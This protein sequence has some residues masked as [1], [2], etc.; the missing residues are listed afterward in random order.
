[1]LYDGKILY[2][3]YSKHEPKAILIEDRAL[4]EMQKNIFLAQWKEGKSETLS[5][6]KQK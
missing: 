4:Y 3:N 6:L 1:M 5:Y 2:T